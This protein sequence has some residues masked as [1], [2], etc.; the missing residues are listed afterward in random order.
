M[1]N[2]KV[3]AFVTIVILTTITLIFWAFFGVYRVFTK[4][5]AP[6]IPANIMEPLNPDLDKNILN[7]LQGRTY[8]EEGQVPEIPI[9]TPTPEELISPEVTITP[10][11]S[12]AAEIL[13]SPTSTATES[14]GLTQ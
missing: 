12:P 3:P 10:S 6:D 7:L 9:L 4:Q 8:F 14:G 2:L 1:K 5:A 13:V 11:A